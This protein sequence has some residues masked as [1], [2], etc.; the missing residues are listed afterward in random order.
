MSSQESVAQAYRVPLSGAAVGVLVREFQLNGPGLNSKTAKRYFRGQRVKDDSRFE[1]T[2]AVAKSLVEEGFV[3]TLPFLDK[4][5]WPID[6]LLTLAMVAS[7][8]R[9]DALAGLMRSASAPVDRPDLAATAY[10]RLATIDLALRVSALLWMANSPSPE[11]VIPSWAEPKGGAQYLKCLLEECGSSAPTRDNLAE[12]VGV[13]FN[14]VD[15]WLD[16]GVRPSLSN[17]RGIA[18]QLALH[19]DG[20]KPSTLLVQ[21]RLNYSLSSIGDILASYLGRETVLDLAAA[22]MR[23]TS[24]NVQGLR[25]FSKLPPDDGALAQL[26]IFICG[27]GFP[28]CEY[29]TKALW[30]REKDPVWRADLE[31]SS[32]P[33]D[34]RL[35]H[36]MKGLG[37]TEQILQMV[38]SEYG[39]PQGIAADLLDEVFRQMPADPTVP[40][41]V[42]HD[43]LEDMNFVRVKGDAAYSARNRMTQY[44]W[45]RAKGDLE[46]AIHHVRRAVELQP[47]NALYHFE[48][49]A[50]LGT[51]GEVSEGIHECWIAAGLDPLWELPKVEVGIILLND[52]RSPEALVHLEHMAEDQENLSAHLAFNLGVARSRCGEHGPALEALLRV[53]ELQADHALAL[54]FA[55]HSA[56]MVG[57]GKTGRRLAK[58]ASGLGQSETYVDWR[59]GKYRQERV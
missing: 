34:L 55:A 22:F 37:G 17:L 29:L 23:F 57:D 21:L 25:E 1:V 43:V 28:S 8:K 40:E 59:K 44:E 50:T 45:A 16:G 27:A 12:Q 33:W 53:V 41:R 4:Q 39:I 49:G 36:L 35:V 6:K 13:S 24:R 47:E 56:F 42:P 5:G 10:L 46:T 31:A 51:A 20:A 52:D 11:E 14:T 48:L 2:E 32:K 18:T 26:A 30:R 7:A 38:Q 3:P 9:W 19:I 15:S 58:K 54:D